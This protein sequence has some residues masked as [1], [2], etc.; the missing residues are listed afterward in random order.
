MGG[1]VQSG[2]Q[3]HDNACSLAEAARQVAVASVAQSPA[4]QKASDAAE[5]TYH[6]AVIASCRANNSSNGLAES[7]MALRALGVTP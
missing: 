4:G 1:K 2:N 7:L 5:I 6:K 3:A